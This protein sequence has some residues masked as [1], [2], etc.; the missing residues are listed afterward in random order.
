MTDE[1]ET[2][3]TPEQ[4]QEVRHLVGEARHTEPMPADVVARL[5]R[6]LEDLADEPS[7]RAPVVHLAR[8]RRRVASLLVAAAAVVVVGIG[9]GQ[10]VGTSGSDSGG[11]AD[12]AADG[13]ASADDQGGSASGEAG[14]ADSV[15]PEREQN[16]DTL[17]EES[18]VAGKLF[19]LRPEELSADL[20]RVQQY[21]GGDYSA[22]APTDSSA[23][24]YRKVSRAC[25]SGD[26]GT[27]T[28]VPVKYGSQPGVV[29]FRRPLG[30]VQVAEVY[31]C[32]NPD[33]VRSLTLPA[34]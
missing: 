26:W 4:D 20:A 32:G 2:P 11:D 12:S 30:D 27:G 14:G 3:L 17:G 23:R 1:Q 34:P 33:P 29:V 6:V 31:L 15:A 5:D 9:I 8:R 18:F 25:R 21:A 16:G 7:R 10:V 19:K 28:F 24:L 13:Q 22:A